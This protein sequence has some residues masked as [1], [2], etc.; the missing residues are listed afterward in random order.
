MRK[1]MWWLFEYFMTPSAFIGDWRGFAWN[2]LGHAFV[3]GWL[4]VSV[5]GA[6]GLFIIPLYALWEYVQWSAEG[7]DTED[8]FRD[9]AFVLA[10]TLAAH[11]SLWFAAPMLLHLFA[12]IYRR[13]S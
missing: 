2:Q 11:V 9:C 10:G 1:L 3:L 4:P 13:V 12:G 5:L 8:C 6:W 7:A